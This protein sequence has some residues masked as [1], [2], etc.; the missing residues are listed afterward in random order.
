MPSPANL[1]PSLWLN[2]LL[3]LCCRFWWHLLFQGLLI[4]WA[5]ADATT[6]LSIHTGPDGS[7]DLDGWLLVATVALF[8]TL[9][10]DWGLLGFHSYLIATGQSTAEHIKRRKGRVPY[11]QDVPR[12]VSPF[13]QGIVQNV[14]HTCCDATTSPYVLPPPAS[15]CSDGQPGNAVRQSLLLLL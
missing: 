7:L 2:T 6:A 5:F 14:L 8:L 3:S 13:S 11:L 10:F 12:H 4:A 9:V 1:R 15:N